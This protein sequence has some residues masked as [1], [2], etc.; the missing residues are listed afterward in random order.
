MIIYDSDWNPQKDLQAMARVHRIGQTKE[1]HVYRLMCRST[2]EERILQVAERKLFLDKMVNQDDAQCT[3][4]TTASRLDFDALLSMLRF[5]ANAVLSADS[6]DRPLTD[7][8]IQQ[9]IVRGGTSNSKDAPSSVLLQ[10]N[11]ASTARSFSENTSADATTSIR[12]FEGV[13]YKK[14][15]GGFSDQTEQWKKEVDGKKRALNSRI[16]FVDGQAV[17]KLDNYDKMG[18]NLS[19]FDHELASA[20]PET[21]KSKAV[22]EF[23]WSDHCQNCL[24]GGELVLCSKCPT[25]YHANCAGYR[26][27]EDVPN[28]YACPHHKCGVC[29]AAASTGGGMLFR[30]V[31]CP[32]SFCEACLPQQVWNTP[33]RMLR[34]HKAF[35]ALGY[36]QQKTACYIVCSDEC[37][38]RGR[39]L[40]ML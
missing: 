1:V 33:G 12:E 15:G 3:E 34:H 40:K 19:V 28:C 11:T 21:K 31:I 20:K 36:P 7:A 39:A 16:T 30:C 32:W 25:V 22:A 23:E 8:D 17:L 24:D 27:I 18:A 29:S 6:A 37:A 38:Q 14:Q 26:T 10:T 4:T 35:E 13:D 2:V 9:L 5:G